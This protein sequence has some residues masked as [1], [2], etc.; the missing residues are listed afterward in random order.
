M[1]VAAHDLSTLHGRVSAALEVVGKKKIDLADHLGIS[2]QALSQILS[3]ERPGHE[4]R[5][6]IADFCGVSLRWLVTGSGG[7]DWSRQSNDDRATELRR[8]NLIIAAITDQLGAAK[9]EIAALRE[10]VRD[11]QR[12]RGDQGPQAADR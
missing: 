5:Q 7:P 4:H 11:L 8:A 2:K 3:G 10:Q 1:S 12:R 9:E 6:K